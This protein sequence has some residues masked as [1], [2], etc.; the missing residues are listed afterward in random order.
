MTKKRIA[1]A[2]TDGIH[3]DAHF[4]KAE[5]FLIYDVGDKSWIWNRRVRCLSKPLKRFLSP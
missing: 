4:G 5:R 3:I 1:A 2:S